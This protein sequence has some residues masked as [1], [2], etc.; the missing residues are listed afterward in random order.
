[1][2]FSKPIEPLTKIPAPTAAAICAQSKPSPAGGA[3][4][5]PGMTPA[6]YLAALEKNKLS[7]DAVNLLAYGLPEK[8]AVCWAAQ[9]SRMTAPKLSPPEM[10]ALQATEA[11][12]KNPSPDARAAV[13]ASLGKVDFTGPASWAAQSAAWAKTPGMPSPPAV[14][15]APP[16]NLV[17]A[18]VAG[19]ILLAAGLSVGSPMPPVPKPKPPPPPGPLPPELLAQLQ[20]PQLPQAPQMAAPVVDQ[21]K[22]MKPLAPFID[23]GKGVAKGTVKCC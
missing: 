19:A 20:K 6:E 1:M 22:M 7:V 12:L 9:G 21:P 2:F 4:L 16:V 13:D 11:W 8:D 10:G 15:G 23:L 3:L 17:A 18:G 14:P 5:T